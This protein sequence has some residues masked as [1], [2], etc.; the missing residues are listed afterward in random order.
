MKIVDRVLSI[1]LSL[2]FVM[3]KMCSGSVVDDGFV[4]K[5]VMI[6]LF[7]ESV[8]VINL[9]ERIVGCRYGMIIS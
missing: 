8:N 9:F 5:N 4:V 3:L 1:G 6:S 2:I 7:I